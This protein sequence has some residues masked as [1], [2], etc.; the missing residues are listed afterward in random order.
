MSSSSGKK[1]DKEGEIFKFISGWVEK[2]RDTPCWVGGRVSHLSIEEEKGGKLA[3]LSRSSRVT[4]SIP[5]GKFEVF[6]HFRENKRTRYFV[7]RVKCLPPKKSSYSD[8]KLA[9]TL[10]KTIPRTEKG[11]K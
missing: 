8:E 9:E 11:G 7:S 1:E 10:S 2:G 4:Q 6:N 3:P 5:I